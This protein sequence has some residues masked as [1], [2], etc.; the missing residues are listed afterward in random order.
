MC[1]RRPYYPQAPY[2]GEPVACPASDYDYC[3]RPRTQCTPTV[4]RESLN[5]YFVDPAGK[6]T[7]PGSEKLPFRT[8]QRAIDVAVDAYTATGSLKNIE[9]G[10]GRYLENL[11]ITKPLQLTGATPSQW[12]GIGSSIVGNITINISGT[13]DQAAAQVGIFNFQIDGYITDVSTTVHNVLL[14]NLNII[15]I[16]DRAIYSNSTASVWT[17]LEHV[18]VSNSATAALGVNPLVEVDTGLLTIDDSTLSANGVQT[19]LLLGGTATLD[20]VQYSTIENNNAATILPSIVVIS[21]TNYASVKRFITNTIQ[22]T[23]ASAAERLLV[24]RTNQNNGI[25]VSGIAGTASNLWVV[26]NG[27]N[28]LSTKVTAGFCVDYSAGSALYLYHNSN[29]SGVNAIGASTGSNNVLP[30]TVLP[31]V[32]VPLAT[33]A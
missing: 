2:Y 23:T 10:F 20:V 3:C 8:I 24:A 17:V 9:V 13:S 30:G 14:Q 4:A 1:C 26:D 28:L 33:V 16:T 6:D 19:V 29:Y 5:T 27:I 18:N 21:T 31:Y 32:N 15:A 7:N 12:A 11:T 25:Y 22:F